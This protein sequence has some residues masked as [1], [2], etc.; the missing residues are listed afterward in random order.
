MDMDFNSM[1]EAELNRSELAGLWLEVRI[2]PVIFTDEDEVGTVEREAWDVSLWLC[3]QDTEVE[4]STLAPGFTIGLNANGLFDE[5]GQ[6]DF[7]VG[8]GVAL[9]DEN[10][11]KMLLSSEMKQLPDAL[12]M[13][14]PDEAGYYSVAMP[15]EAG[16]EI[17]TVYMPDMDLS[18]YRNDVLATR[19]AGSGA[20]M[21]MND[22]EGL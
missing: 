7:I 15:V 5:T 19:Y 18:F 17:W 22:A 4:I 13:S 9:V 6:D 16:D 20:Y 12:P 10:G 3:T 2:D 21:L 1:E 11:K 8:N 14:K